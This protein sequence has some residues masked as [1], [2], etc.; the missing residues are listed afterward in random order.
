MRNVR[1][2][3]LIGHRAKLSCEEI[4]DA[5]SQIVHRTGDLDG[6]IRLHFGE[7]RTALANV[8]HRDFYI[9]ARDGINKR[10]ILRRP[11]AG[12]RG[13]RYCGFYFRQQAREIAE[14]GIVNGALNR[15]ARRMAHDPNHLCPGEFTGKLHTAKDVGVFDITCHAT[16][17]DVTIAETFQAPC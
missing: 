13:C 9:F 2:G 12:I 15:T 14:F 5:R 1:F 3:K 8:G 6:T 10:I 7:H 17:K 4:D 16:V 11:L